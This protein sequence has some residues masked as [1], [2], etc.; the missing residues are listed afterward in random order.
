MPTNQWFIGKYIKEKEKRAEKALNIIAIFLAGDAKLR[1]T[2]D[3]GALKSSIV[4][5]KEKLTRFIGSIMD[6]A[7]FVEDGTKNK[8]GSV[9][10]A[11]KPYLKPAL[12]ENIKQ[13]QKLFNSVMKV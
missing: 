6:Y 13:I 5:V 12:D 11:A 1:V 7:K 2:V 3:T 9:R 10:M 4:S 8:D